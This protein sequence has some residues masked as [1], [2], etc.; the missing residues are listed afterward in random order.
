[1]PFQNFEDKRGEV[2]SI[3]GFQTDIW[4]ADTLPVKD[5]FWQLKSKRD[6]LPKNEVNM[7]LTSIICHRNTD[8]LRPNK[9]LGVFH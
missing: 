4:Q 3:C 7:F 2:V 9:I 6:F 5:L 1:M 8:A